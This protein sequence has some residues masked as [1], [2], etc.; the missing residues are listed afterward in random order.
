MSLSSCT[1]YFEGIQVSDN[2]KKV[3]V[4]MT[5]REVVGIMGRDY[6]VVEVHGGTR[7]IAYW[8]TA[9]DGT[10]VTEYRFHF[11]DGRL[12]SFSKEDGRRHHPTHR[13]GQP[14]R[15]GERGR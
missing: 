6:E 7:V 10:P 2:V 1:A 13:P 9:S 5:E 11:R 15:R 4:G 14:H 3:E 8:Q 12:Q